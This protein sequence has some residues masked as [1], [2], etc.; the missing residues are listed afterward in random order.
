M[1][2]TVRTVIFDNKN[3]YLLKPI[4][5]TKLHH[6]VERFNQIKGL[7]LPGRKINTVR[8]SFTDNYRKIILPLMEG[9]I[10]NDLDDIVRCESEDNHSMFCF[11]N[12]E[13][14]LVSKSLNKFENILSGINFCR[15]HNKHLVNLKYITKTSGEKAVTS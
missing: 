10:I 12:N 15:I 5:H 13:K 7:T 3:K 9:L 6:A 4:S 2:N 11:L 1:R 14:I 8:E